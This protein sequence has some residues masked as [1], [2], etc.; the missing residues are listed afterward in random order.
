MAGD[1]VVGARAEHGLPERVPEYDEQG[2]LKSQMF[3]E[4]AKSL[5]DGNVEITGLKI[6]FYEGT[7]V[8]VRVTAPLCVFDRVR[9]VAQ[10]DG[11]VRIARD[12]M[13]ITGTGFQFD[14][15]D[16]RFK[17]RSKAKVVLKGG[18]REMNKGN[19]P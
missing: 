10:S 16:E 3:G 2:R 5:P 15:K 12:N 6:E 8:N 9:N 13:V 14:K 17:I 19:L 7:Q 1:R 4:L 11:P 18:R